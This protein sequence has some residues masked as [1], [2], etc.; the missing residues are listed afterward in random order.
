MVPWGR[1]YS[2]CQFRKRNAYCVDYFKKRLDVGSL[3]LWASCSYRMFLLQSS[4]IQAQEWRGDCYLCRRE[5]RLW[6]VRLVKWKTKKSRCRKES[7]RS[8]YLGHLLERGWFPFIRLLF[9]RNRQGIAL[10]A[11]RLGRKNLWRRTGIHLRAPLADY[12]DRVGRSTRQVRLQERQGFRIRRS[13][14]VIPRL[15]EK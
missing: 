11:R 4:F 3:S 9:W 15:Q 7:F 2:R 1:L 10:F 6:F 12:A 5:S 13:C 14:R 8:R